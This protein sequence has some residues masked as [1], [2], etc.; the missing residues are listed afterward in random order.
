MFFSSHLMASTDEATQIPYCLRLA[1]IQHMRDLCALAAHCAVRM[2]LR[3]CASLEWIMAVCLQV[4]LRIGRD[5]H[6]GCWTEVA[7]FPTAPLGG[8]LR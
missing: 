2:M 6:I 4:A 3:C 5:V 8:A 1:G 7:R